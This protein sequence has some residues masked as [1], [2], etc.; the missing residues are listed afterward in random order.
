MMIQAR[1]VDEGIRESRT[2]AILHFTFQALQPQ[3]WG[4]R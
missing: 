3:A 4:G 2:E 1:E